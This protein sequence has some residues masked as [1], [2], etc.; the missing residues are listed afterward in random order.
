MYGL[1]IFFMK[2][3]LHKADE[4]GQVNMGWLDSHHSFSFGHYQDEAKIHFGAL[5]VLNDDIVSGG[6]GFGKHPHDNME[7][8]SIPIIGDLEHADSTGTQAVIKQNDVQIMSAGK[9]IQHSEKNHN[10]KE[11]VNFL[12]IWIFP[13]E[14]NIKPRYDQKNFDPSN[15]K[16]KLEIVVAPD[17][18]SAIWINQD[19]WL[20]LGNFSKDFKTNYTLHKP[21][22]GVYV[23]VLNGSIKI[24]A[25]ILNKKDA[26]GVWETNDVEIVAESDAEI[27]LIDVP[28]EFQ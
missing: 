13:K 20:S 7:I 24:G 9:G 18:E 8:I 3:I 14:K 6:G 10:S 12:Q 5:R 27:L 1:V 4:R 28:I 25:Q 2:T 21:G 16:D 19:A 22:N 11:A 17:N 23:F 26:L 15:R